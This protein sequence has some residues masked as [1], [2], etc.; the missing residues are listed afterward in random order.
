ME[1]QEYKDLVV[2]R[3]NSLPE[4]EQAIVASMDGT[5]VGDILMKVLGPELLGGSNPEEAT[6]TEKP[7]Q[8]MPQAPAPQ[9]QMQ[10]APVQRAGLGSR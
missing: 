10:Q 2:N 1:L 3:L 9:G 5:P 7:Q 8:P 4:E 6:P